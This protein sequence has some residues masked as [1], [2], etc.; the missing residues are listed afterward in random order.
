MTPSF[1]RTVPSPDSPAFAPLTATFEPRLPH[2]NA[3]FGADGRAA[4]EA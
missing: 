2:V 4:A 1:A 3:V